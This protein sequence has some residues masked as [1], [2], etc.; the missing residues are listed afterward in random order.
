MVRSFVYAELEMSSRFLRDNIEK[1]VEYMSLEFRK[2][3]WARVTNV[4]ET[5]E[6]TEY[7]SSVL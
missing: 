6:N 5:I 2:D 7:L 4:H 1:R 3:M